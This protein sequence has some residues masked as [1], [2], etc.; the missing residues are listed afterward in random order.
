M[1]CFRCFLIIGWPWIADNR[2]ILLGGLPIV[3]IWRFLIWM[4]IGLLVYFSYGIPHSVLAK[5]A[6]NAVADI[7]SP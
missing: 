1:Y 3:S 7:K 4:G 5:I 2:F 6:N